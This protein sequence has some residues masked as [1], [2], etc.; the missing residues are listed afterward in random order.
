MSRSG[1][2]L[3]LK[4]VQVRGV[5]DLLRLPLMK[6]SGGHSAHWGKAHRSS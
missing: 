2:G 4:L 6:I 1:P 5:V 3:L